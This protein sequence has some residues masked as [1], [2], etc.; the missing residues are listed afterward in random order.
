MRSLSEMR[1]AILRI[2]QLIGP[3][4][5][6]FVDDRWSACTAE[7]GLDASTS[8]W[9]EFPFADVAPRADDTS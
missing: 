9:L 5:E 8:R 2:D 7:G 1:P 4:V 6:T 3:V